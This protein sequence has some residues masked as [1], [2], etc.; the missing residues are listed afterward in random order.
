MK[1]SVIVPTYNNKGMLK[2]LMNIWQGYGADFKANAEIIIVDD[3][4]KEPAVET[5]KEWETENGKVG[6]SLSVYRVLKDI[7]WNLGGALNLGVQ[8][9]KGKWVANIEVDHVIMPDEM[10]RFMVALENLD[11]NKWYKFPRILHKDK[12]HTHPGYGLFLI[13][14]EN[15]WKAGGHDEDFAGSIGSHQTFLDSCESLFGEYLLADVTMEVYNAYDKIDNW[16][17]KGLSRDQG[18]FYK[19]LGKKRSGEMP[20]SKDFIRFPWRKDL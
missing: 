4:W 18:R 14:K 9:A 2:H 3:C 16:Q 5:V 15:Y 13:T 12:K 20:V 6:Y 19:L 1:L 10:E 7:P 11:E 17:T 8:Q